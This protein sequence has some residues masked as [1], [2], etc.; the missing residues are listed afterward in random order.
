MAHNLTDSQRD[1]Q[2][3]LNNRYALS[4]VEEHLALGGL[5][6]H[7]ERV[8]TKQQVADLLEVSDSTKN[9]QRIQGTSRCLPRK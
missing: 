8:F 4:K 1:R 6:F 2:N 5:T 9:S 3:I 7:K